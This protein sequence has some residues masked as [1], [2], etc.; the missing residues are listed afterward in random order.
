MR[1]EIKRMWINQPSRSQQFHDLH[2]TNVLAVHEYDDTWRIYFLSG[3]VISH[4]IS[5]LALSEG[6]M[7][8][9]KLAATIF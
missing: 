3:N 7:E 4:Q 6:W 9:G 8:P 2:G 5:R 1:K